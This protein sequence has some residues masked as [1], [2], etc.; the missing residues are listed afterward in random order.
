[1]K[2]SPDGGKILVIAQAPGA[3]A[4]AYVIDATQLQPIADTPCPAATDRASWA[5]QGDRI[6]LACGQTAHIWNY[7]SGEVVR[8]SVSEHISRLQL[9]ASGDRLAALVNVGDDMDY[10]LWFYTLPSGKRDP[11]PIA[12][13]AANRLVAFEPT[14]RRFASGCDFMSTS[15]STAQECDVQLCEL[16]SGRLLTKLRVQQRATLFF[17][18]KGDR[19]AAYEGGEM[20]VW[21]AHDG[22]VIGRWTTP[23]GGRKEPAFTDDGRHLVAMDG[24]WTRVAEAQSGE[25]AAMFPTDSQVLTLGVGEDA[26]LAVT[27]HAES[28]VIEIWQLQALRR[29]AGFGYAGAVLTFSFS[30]DGG[31]LLTTGLEARGSDADV[32][33]LWDWT[34]GRV[35]RKGTADDDGSW[36][37]TWARETASSAGSS[38][39]SDKA[40]VLKQRDWPDEVRNARTIRLSND[41]STMATS[42]VDGLKVWHVA[43][44]QELARIRILG[45]PNV[46]GFTPDG[47]YVV[48]GVGT[49]LQAWRWRLEDLRREACSSLRANLQSATWRAL[50]GS[51]QAWRGL[52]GPR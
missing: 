3:E 1:M 49:Q 16:D 31:Q 21:S 50:A 10:R 11:E 52:C 19:L 2:S 25:D 44:G 12:C 38:D 18:A 34:S 26:H 41:G 42:R 48:A 33:K 45:E 20:K 27:A 7:R 6:T 37:P 24:K 36:R 8:A 43:S 30:P 5:P 51:V 23:G 13:A 29:R 28:G 4:R 46:L 22:L 32:V 47:K 40:R 14:G 15:D 39:K 35:L 9:A 17:D